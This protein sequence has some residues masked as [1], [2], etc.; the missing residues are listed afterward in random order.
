MKNKFYILIFLFLFI[1]PSTAENLSIE[2]KNITLDK[3]NET[4][5]FQNEVLIKNESKN[6]IRS[7]YAE[8]NK[9]TGIINL[10][11][12]IE[13]L[14]VKGNKIKT[15]RAEYNEASKVFKSFGG[16]EITTKNGYLIS[17][18][19]IILD[20]EKNFIK[21]N[22]KTIIIDKENNKID[23]DNFEY[24]TNNNIFKSVG[25]IK[26][27]DSKGNNYEFSQI[28]IDTIKKEIIGSDIKAYLNQKEFKINENNKPRIFSNTISLKKE[29]S[30]FEKSIFTL[31]NYR[32]KDKCPPWSIQASKMLHDNKKKTIY[33]DNAVLK[34][35]DFPIFY[36]P[37]LS[38]PDPTVER[39]TGFLL[40]T[41]SDSKNLGVGVSIPYFWD[42][43]NDKNF[44]LTN[45][46]YFN[47]NPLFM[48]E[49]HQA[50]KNS[51]IIFDFGYTEGYKK[52]TSSKKAGEKSH[53]F[54]KFTKN[55]ES[56]NNSESSLD[57][58]LQ[59]M[60]NDKYMKL[61]RINSNL[62]D[63]N[64]NTLENSLNY[65]F[66]N[67]DLF[68]GLNTSIYETLKDDYNDKYEYIFPEI[69]FDK[70]L[71]SNNKFGIL[72]LQTNYKFHNYDTN[73]STNFLVNNLDWNFKDL[74]FN[75]GLQSKII[76]QIKNINYESKNVEL[77]KEEPTNEIFGALGLLNEI[78]LQKSD[79]FSNHLL[80]PKL[81]LRYS[82]GSMRK[83]N[84]G[85]RLNPI[86][87]FSLDR[88]NNLNNFETGLSATFGFDY[89][90][91]NKNNSR[92]FDFSVA[93]IINEKENKKMHSKSSLDEKL[94]DLVGTANVK[95]SKN[96]NLN[97]NFAIDENYNDINYNEV[98]TTLKF[99]FASL[100]FDYL[101]EKNHIGDQE[102]FKTKLDIFK[103]SDGLFSFGT[104]RNLVTNS[105]EYYNMS[106]EYINDCLKAGLVYRREFYTDSELEPENSLMFKITLVPFGDISTPSFNQ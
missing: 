92:N 68:L 28:Y 105:A 95:L 3:K 37:K 61:Y 82:P 73:K 106:Y 24:N 48:G 42:L 21:S 94:S 49:Y 99:D 78:N 85:F 86:N 25:F 89:N 5:I 41:L 100:N 93:Q 98:G 6:Q 90:F 64:Q 83:E 29:K 62:V 69:T 52:T 70:N 53:F 43:G 59:E 34:V 75:S 54:A 44:T 19:D 58:S 65:S 101:Q 2:A 77:Y 81:L 10:Q 30:S 13:A 18:E 60:S 9:K 97:Y 47:E 4:S 103:N 50:F 14:D 32:E 12:K 67:E 23:L 26:I 88:I 51:S 20:N 1:R 22:K 91:S 15:E 31:C 80:T 11:N 45:N 96:T 74:N 63:Y 17:S 76:G 66:E 33:Y 84:E 7:D 39:R 79:K 16:T 104:K 8:Y 102:Y 57:I 35:Y 38:H 71:F 72:D 27:E 40:P 87:A 55:F 36:F 56:R 46:F